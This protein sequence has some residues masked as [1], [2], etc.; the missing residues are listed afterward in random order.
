MILFLYDSYIVIILTILDQCIELIK[1]KL[2]ILF[3]YQIT[4][5][6]FPCA[7]LSSSLNINK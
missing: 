1:T 4:R 5:V 6:Q 3:H 2:I 7:I